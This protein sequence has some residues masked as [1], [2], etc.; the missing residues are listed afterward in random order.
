MHFAPTSKL[1]SAVG[2]LLP[3]AWFNLFVIGLTAFLTVVDLFA[4]QAILPALA[5][6]YDATPAAMGAAVNASTIGMAAAGLIVALYNARIPRRQGIIAS[7]VLLALPTAL[8]AFAPDLTTF[9]VLRVAQGLCMSAAFTLTL[10]HLGERCTVSASPAAFAAYVTGN[11]ASNL[12]GR[13]LAAGVVDGFGVE[14]N[15]LVFAALNLAGALLVA[16]TISNAPPN[17]SLMH[18]QRSP[19]DAFRLHFSTR[20]L[21]ICFAIGFLI[22]FAFIGA[23]SYV[24]FVLVR[25]PFSLPA[26]SLGLVYLVFLLALLT[27]PFAGETA[28]RLGA[29]RAI[30]VALLAAA[31]GLA[32]TLSPQLPLV[33]AGLAVLGAGT[34]F[35]QAAATG[36]VARV[37]QTDKGSASGLYLTFYY[38]G[39]L[40]GAHLLGLAFMQFGWTGCVI[41]AAVALIL[42]AALGASLSTKGIVK[43]ENP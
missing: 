3:N 19:V 38:L 23:F 32:L 18:P 26:K 42:G 41:G 9:A 40:A 14:T 43:H 30:A 17:P 34:F 35:A 29:G 13:M 22:L 8:L 28:R 27:T 31:F 21:R 12:F 24:N 7:L 37:A 5:L 20:D 10:A 11:V 15:F 4:T 39:G 6:R 25:A 33:L 16:L 36:F 1:G 2:R